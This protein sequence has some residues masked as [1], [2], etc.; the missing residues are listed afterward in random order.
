M[1]KP[2]KQTDN[3]ITAAEATVA[4]FEKQRLA[5]LDKQAKLVDRRRAVAFDAA[6]GDTASG[7]LIDGLAREAAELHMRVD[8]IDDAIAEAQRRL[9]QARQHA[10]RAE[11]LAKAKA[12]RQT[13]GKFVA[14][15]KA[16][17]GALQVLVIAGNEMRDAISEMNQLG[18]SHPSHAQL[19]SLGALALRTA[20]TQTY[21]VRYFERISP[22]EAKTFAG[23]VAS[24]STTVERVIETKLGE[25][26]TE[27]A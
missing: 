27:A 20:L 22:V 11:E 26:T 18:C 2:T 3:A 12:L 5:L 16:L 13:L 25:Q 14:A 21:W 9:H 24:W 15:G 17:D 19:E 1:S 8:A 4:G 23:L 10:A 7:K 6:N